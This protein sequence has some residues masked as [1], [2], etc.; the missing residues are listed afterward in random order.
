VD[1]ELSELE[2]ALLERHLSVCAPCRTFDA[3]L[4]STA[5]ALR[6]APLEQPA[7]RVRVP[8]RPRVAVSIPGGRRFALV[9]VA[10]ALALGS[11]VGSSLRSPAPAPTAPEPRVS[12]LTRDVSQLRQIPRGRHVSPLTP[13]E[14]GGPAEGII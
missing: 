11:L 14:P 4:R 8:A 13:R 1:E 7:T 6:A 5:A 3:Q 2:S 9:A 12:L 10:A